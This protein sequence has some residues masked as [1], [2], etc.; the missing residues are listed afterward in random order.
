MR[1]RWVR[2]LG[3]WTLLGLLSS[4]Q[5]YLAHRRLTV[6]PFTWAEAL[7]DGL[8]FWYLWAIAALSTENLLPDWLVT[9]KDQ[10]IGDKLPGAS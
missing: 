8:A 5:V 10:S 1:A 3:F 4:I 7:R 6:Y 9:Q 2:I